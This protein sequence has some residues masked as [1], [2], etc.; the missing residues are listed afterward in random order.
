MIAMRADIRLW[1]A[2]AVIG[3][4]GFAVARGI[5][6]VHFALAL[7]DVGS[8][9]SRAAIAKNWGTAPDVASTAL[10]ADLNYQIDPSDQKA[11]EH[12][13]Q[14]VAALAL[15]EP[16]SS[17]NWLSLSG[18]QLITDQPM[19]QVFDSLE[20]SMLTG[21]NEGDVAVERAV[22]EASL[23][24]RLPADLKNRAALDVAT[25]MVPQ[26]QAEAEAIGKFRAVL[27]TQ[28]D[29]VR[30]ELREA[31][32]ASGVRPQDIEKQLGF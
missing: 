16:M 25:M 30:N 2:V 14:T 28:P 23:W 10:Q 4:C 19:D 12:R 15:I 31:L 5:G 32:V 3:I 13:R 9:E 22:F 24:E 11:A 21:P 20:L 17:S 27:A 7:A 29:W 8:A 6:I 18:L 26:T 1:T